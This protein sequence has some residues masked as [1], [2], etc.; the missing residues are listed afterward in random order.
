MM[1]YPPALLGLL[2][3][4]I[5][6][7]LG[8]TLAQ[9]PSDS[10]GTPHLQDTLYLLDSTY[11]EIDIDH[12]EIYQHYRSGTIDTFLCS[13]GNPGLRDGEATRP[14]IFTI[15][16]KE[17]KHI[18]AQFDVP[19]INWMPFDAGIGIH[20]LEGKGYY[21]FLGYQ[22]SSHGCVR[23]SRE[24]SEDLFITVPVGTVVYVHQQNATRAVGFANANDNI[25]VIT[26]RDARLLGKR[27]AAAL[28]GRA[29]DRSLREKL[30][31]PANGKLRMMIDVVNDRNKR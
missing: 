29:D 25:R 14:G 18:S 1:R 21:N 19:M 8:R 16:S 31:I 28:A 26:P 5:L 12:Q 11:L 24:S 2:P 22:A 15:R 6:M 23:V 4:L 17:R 13:T 20:A 27:L 30:A 3:I 10:S 9:S 7:S